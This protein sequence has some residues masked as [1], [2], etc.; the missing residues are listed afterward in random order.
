MYGSSQQHHPQ[1]SDLSMMDMTLADP[2]S[3]IDRARRQPSRT[4]SSSNVHPRSVPD[5]PIQPFISNTHQPSTV[6]GNRLDMMHLVEQ[7]DASGPSRALAG[8]A[9][10]IDQSPTSP[11]WLNLPSPP[12]AEQNTSAS[13]RST[14]SLRYPVLRPLLPLIESVIPRSSACDLLDV[15]F[16]SSSYAQLRPL[17]PHILGYV[18]RKK[19]FLHPTKPRVSSPALLASMLW[20]AAQTSNAS[21]LNSHPAARG[22]VCRKLLELTVDL[23][24]PLIHSPVP[25]G[26]SLHGP[27]NHIIDDVS[28]GVLG[29]STDHVG[30]EGSITAHVD[31]LATYIHLATVVSAS[32]RKAASLRWWGAAWS[33][34]RELKFGREAPPSP[35]QH[36]LGDFRGESSIP[37]GD[38]ENDTREQNQPL[39]HQSKGF[40]T[41]SSRRPGFMTEEEREERRR[42]WWLLYMMDRHL[43]LCYNRPLALLD[44]ECEGL[45]QP[46]DDTAWQSGQFPTIDSTY[47]SY[48]RRGPSVEC[49]GQSIFGYFLPLMTILGN[50]VQLNQS[51]NRPT[52]GTGFH[53][54][55]KWDDH[56]QE[57]VHQLDLY[58][59]CLR[60]LNLQTSLGG[61]DLSLENRLN[62]APTPS[63][64][65]ASTTDSQMANE[66]S[67][68]KKTTI[69][70]GTHIM[71]VLHI[72]LAGK[73]DPITL[74]D[75]NDLWISTQGFLTASDHAIAAAGAVSGI[76][77]HDPDLSFMP[78]FFG[79]YLLQGSFLL[80]LFADKLQGDVSPDVVKAC[81][82]VI[83]AHEACVV[84]LDTQYQ[85]RVGASVFLASS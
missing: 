39:L 44:N 71:H 55:S 16:T 41:D 45:L 3:D 74:L 77:E 67:V 36:E 27:T 28:L 1:H 51:R 9:A 70:Y 82:T 22:R 42:V 47:S 65:S 54:P 34:A 80:L 38:F 11:A 66:L 81:E 37:K 43:A 12:F 5:Y 6:A 79:V 46:M 78:F 72:L 83:R 33:I 49:T 25:G 18:F 62:E 61:G 35:P 60:D 48:R 84:T 20:I 73:W 32:E 24:K 7:H 2:M 75:D 26:T 40:L 57:I 29:V 76:L 63:V 58:A 17:S 13:S 53:N 19:S 15:Y 31:V 64:R 52:F 59:Q 10:F 56:I 14:D 21:F 8:D 85:V 23:L 50:I 4:F 68:Q 30:F 69:A